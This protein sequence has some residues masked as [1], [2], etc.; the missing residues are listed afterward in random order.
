MPQVFAVL[1]LIAMITSLT[2]NQYLE[3]SWRASVLIPL[4]AGPIV[5]A[6]YRTYIYSNLVSPIRHIPQPK[7]ALPFIGHDLALFQQ[8]PAQDFSRWMRE[9]ENDGLVSIPTS[10]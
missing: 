8:P 4:V 10:A 3:L 7:G 6:T 1:V 9:V 2:I 5:Y